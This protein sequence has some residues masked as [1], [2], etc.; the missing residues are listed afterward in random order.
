[1]DEKVSALSDMLDKLGTLGSADQVA[2]FFRQEKIRGKRAEMDSCPVAQYAWRELGGIRIWVNPFDAGEAAEAGIPDF[3]GDA[4]VG[5]YDCV[6]GTGVK[7]PDAVNAFAIAFDA[8]KY[9]D[10]AE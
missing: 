8:G 7:L 3:G 9:E 6:G 4:G 1:M 5:F 2:D 10:L